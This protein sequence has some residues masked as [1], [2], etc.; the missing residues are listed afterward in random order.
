MSLNRR[1]GIYNQEAMKFVIKQ[2]HRVP[3]NC[4]F[5]PPPPFP[6]LPNQILKKFSLFGRGGGLS[7]NAIPIS[8]GIYLPTPVGPKKAK[9]AMGLEGS[10]IP[11][12]E[13]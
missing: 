5:I 7:I 13:R 4:A 11:A 8:H 1:E 10:D 6:S 2:H 3:L 12:L 9:V